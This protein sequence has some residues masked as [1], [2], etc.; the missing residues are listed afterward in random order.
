LS[1]LG[2]GTLTLTGLNSLTGNT[3]VNAG[4][5][6]VSGSLD[7]ASVLVNSGGTLTGGGS[8]GG[9]VTV[10]D[11][12]HL[13]GATGSTLSVNSLVFNANSNFDVGLGCRFPVAAMRW[14]TS[15]AT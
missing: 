7:S 13:A 4:T 3:T 5:L 10:A 9:A 12:G 6:N 11:G 14:S 1:K 2:T 15:A 8:L